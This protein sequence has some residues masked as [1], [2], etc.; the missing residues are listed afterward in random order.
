[1]PR[2][3]ASEVQAIYATSVTLDPYIAL[4]HSV[5]EGRISA[6]NECGLTEEE[7]TQLETWLA[8]HFAATAPTSGASG[9]SITSEKEGQ[10]SRSY[11]G[12]YGLRLESSQYGQAVQMLDRCNVLVDAG[13]TRAQWAVL[14]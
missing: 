4:A 12:Q 2:T 7:L 9:G 10:L 1:M 5:V 6:F 13:K 11:G 3:T 8:A 14:L